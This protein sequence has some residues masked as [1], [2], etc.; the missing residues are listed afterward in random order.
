MK[1]RSQDAPAP[2]CSV[3]LGGGRAVS[4]PG[5]PLTRAVSEVPKAQVKTLMPSEGGW[6]L[7][8]GFKVMWITLRLCYLCR[9]VFS[10]WLFDLY[11][12]ARE[13]LKVLKNTSQVK[14][15]ELRILPTGIWGSSFRAFNVSIFQFLPKWDEF[16][17]WQE[18]QSSQEQQVCCQ[19]FGIPQKWKRKRRTVNEWRKSPK[20]GKEL[21]DVSWGGSSCRWAIQNPF[22]GHSGPSL[23]PHL[24]WFSTSY[25]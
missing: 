8:S 11:L 18:K 12:L 15:L 14:A 20:V 25:I 6:E 19:T 21:E 23:P 5:S 13:G 9:K 17:W 10:G 1:V 4:D 22:Q 7:C 3:S 24:H 16:P 2:L